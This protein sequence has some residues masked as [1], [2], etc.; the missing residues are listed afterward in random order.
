MA[1]AS[2]PLLQV[3]IPFCILFIF[4]FFCCTFLW[5]LA[6]VLSEGL[7]HCVDVVGLLKS[8]VER[9]CPWILTCLCILFPSK[10]ENIQDAQ[11]IS[12][13]MRNNSTTVHYKITTTTTQEVHVLVWNCN[14]SYVDMVTHVQ[15]LFSCT[16]RLKVGLWL[17][18]MFLWNWRAFF[19]TV[20]LQRIQRL[21]SK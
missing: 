9:T 17:R 5:L 4:I 15:V 2:L 18:F 6:S 11:V 14:F 16:W 8:T 3:L 1:V 12:V 10:I 20:H 7:N 13:P 19:S 21:R